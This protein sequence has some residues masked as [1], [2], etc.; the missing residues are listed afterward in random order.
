MNI[1]KNIS[2]G[3]FILF[4]VIIILSFIRGYFYPVESNF[5]L[6]SFGIPI[7]V[8]EF[9]SLLV[10]LII[11]RI[12]WDKKMLK[13]SNSKGKMHPILAL[14]LIVSFGIVVCALYK[15]YLLFLFLILSLLSKL[16][17]INKENYGEHEKFAVLMMT[18]II[19]AFLLAFICGGI[20]GKYFPDQQKLLIDEMVKQ[21]G[22][23]E[24]V[25]DEGVRKTINPMAVFICGI[26]YYILLTIFNT[27]NIIRYEIDTTETDEEGEVRE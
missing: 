21:Q 26:L 24:D 15:N 3:I 16:I 1:Q 25:G 18:S 7:L 23:F 27:F 14:V 19:I 6:V 9:V 4:N 20:V 22:T 2:K 8:I 17:L 13:R 5:W 10:I 12:K 11:P